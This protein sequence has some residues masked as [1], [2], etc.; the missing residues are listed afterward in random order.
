MNDKE[1][2]SVDRL[3]AAYEAMLKRVHEAAESAEE[4]TVPW[5]RE[6]LQ[7]LRE[8]AV[9]LGELSREEADRVSRYV[10]RDLQDAASFIVETG[11]EF[12]DWLSTDWQLLQDRMLEMF[13]GM[14]D[15][16]SQALQ[17]FAEQA[18]TAGRYQ[19]GE[20]TVPGTLRCVACGAELRIKKTG[21]VP[22]CPKCQATRFERRPGAAQD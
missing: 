19:T 18:R 3:V 2:D 22:P 14:A 21:P 5:L 1:K 16:T 15:Q 17:E 6:T 8:R 12:R 10:E 20:I 13:A 4:K 9:E 7:D 11:Q